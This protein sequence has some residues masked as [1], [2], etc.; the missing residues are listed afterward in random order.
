MYQQNCIS[1]VTK[2]SVYTDILAKSPVFRPYFCDFVQVKRVIELFD[3]QVNNA[4]NVH[5]SQKDDNISKT[6]FCPYFARIFAKN[7]PVFLQK[8]ARM[9]N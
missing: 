2:S 5:N 7:V 1:S 4:L 8:W 3:K 6:W 9:K